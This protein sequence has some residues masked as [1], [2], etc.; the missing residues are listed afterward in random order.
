M[1]GKEV[2]FFS[3]LSSDLGTTCSSSG[4]I[5]GHV[6]SF[7]LVLNLVNHAFA[8]GKRHQ[9]QLDSLHNQE[10]QRFNLRNEI[11][12]RGTTSKQVAFRLK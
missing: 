1:L 3:D 6:V 9:D 11:C 12:L 10:K 2:M 7:E 5:Q 4:P 8:R